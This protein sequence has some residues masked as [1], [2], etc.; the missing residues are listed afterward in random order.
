MS[1][2]NANMM[3]YIEAANLLKKY[4]IRVVDSKYIESEDDAVSFSNGDTIVMKVLSD[5]ALHK[6]KSGVIKL[7]LSKE[8][9]IRTAYKDL[10][11]KSADLKPYKILAQKMIKGGIEIII[12][13][14]TDPSFGKVLL[15][16]FGGIYVETF[17]DVSMRVCPINEFDAGNMISELKSKR[18]IAP[19]EKSENMI[20]DLLMKVSKLLVENDN[21]S[22]LDL[23]PLILHDG[24][25]DAVDLRFI[26]KGE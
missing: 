14:N 12:G 6:T 22:E 8:D 9:D 18:I 24:T 3:D 21:I 4:S 2:E 16:G 7:D 17:K 10:I 1:D 11:E 13:G 20:K 15:L 5:K 19:D 25:Y 23:N 26:L